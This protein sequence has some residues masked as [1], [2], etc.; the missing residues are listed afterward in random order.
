MKTIFLHN[1][2]HKSQTRTIF[3]AYNKHHKIETQ[4]THQS[5][6]AANVIVIH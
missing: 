2:V 1:I 3:Q 4:K 6:E 5:L